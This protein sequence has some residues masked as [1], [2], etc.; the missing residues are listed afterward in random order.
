MVK[1]RCV[2]QRRGC[3]WTEGVGDLLRAELGVIIIRRDP[4]NGVL[5]LLR[6]VVRSD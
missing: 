3:S 1:K 6:P 5:P 4:D 2:C